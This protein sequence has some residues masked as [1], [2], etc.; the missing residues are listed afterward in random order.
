MNDITQANSKPS[1]SSATSH[2][3]P[4]SM[5]ILQ[6][7]YLLLGASFLLWSIAQSLDYNFRILSVFIL[8]AATQ[9]LTLSIT[10]FIYSTKSL[11][12][13]FYSSFIWILISTLLIIVLILPLF[14]YLKP[15][16]NED[17]GGLIYFFAYFLL[18]MF[19]LAP[20]LIA[21]ATAF[22]FIRKNLKN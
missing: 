1:L 8:I 20:L 21:N 14:Q 12:I 16:A 9:F 17:Y 19:V 3:K 15:N 22:L 18:M 4:K 10:L 6:W 13:G 11:K 2:I 7:V 5:K